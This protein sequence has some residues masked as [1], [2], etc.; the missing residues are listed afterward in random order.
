MGQGSSATVKSCKKQVGRALEFKEDFRFSASDSSDTDSHS[1]SSISSVDFNSSVSES[2]SDAEEAEQTEKL[3]VKIVQTKDD[4]L[5]EMAYNEYKL[6]KTI[7]HPNIVK[8]YDA[9]FNEARKTVYLVMNQVQGE[10]LS[11]FDGFSENK[12]KIIFKQLLEVIEYLQ[13]Q[14]ICHRDINPNN[15]IIDGEKLTLIDFNISR[16]FKDAKTLNPIVMMTNAGTPKYQAPEMLDDSYD[17]KIDNWSAGC[18]L[19]YMLTGKHAF[20][21]STIDQIESALKTGSYQ[22][23]PLANVS[24]DAQNLV[25]S[26]LTVDSN[27]RFDIKKSLEHKWLH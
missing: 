15:L 16:R 3:A 21:Y 19:Y 7:S 20:E 22:K 8:M 1:I 23:G 6:L 13:R 4:E 5:T 9:F 14:G 12:A 18:V 24:K 27:N 25:T 11:S 17:Q 10:S 2:D 26:L